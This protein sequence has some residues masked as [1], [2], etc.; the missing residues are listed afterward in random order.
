[1]RYIVDSREGDI[2]L[3]NTLKLDS[4]IGTDKIKFTEIEQKCFKC[5]G[6]EVSTGDI[7]IEY[8]FNKDDEWIKTNLSIEL[9]R[10]GD[11]ATTLFSNMKR[12]KNELQRVKDAGLKFWILTD[13]N[14]EDVKNHFKKL[15]AMR[16]ISYKT[17]AYLTFLNNYLDVASDF[18]IVCCGKDWEDTIRRICKRHIIKNKLQYRE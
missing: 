17:D 13:W 8:R 16:K 14:L 3:L 10:G 5:E 18:N 2:N 15:Q 4:K 1:M 11:F 6:V 9:K 12:F 7:G